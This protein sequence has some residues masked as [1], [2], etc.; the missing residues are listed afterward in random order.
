M[1]RLR[2][3]TPYY[4]WELNIQTLIFIEHWL[5]KAD[6]PRKFWG[7]RNRAY[8]SSLIGYNLIGGV[9]ISMLTSIVV[10]CGFDSRSCVKSRTIK[11]VYTASLE[12]MQHLEVRA[13]NQDN[14]FTR[15]LLFQWA[16][17]V[18]IQLTVLV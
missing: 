16:R 12:S 4:W 17:D 3:S 6:S 2:S 11:W 10:D 14:V 15:R 7:Y 5:Y 13:R 18:K 1:I 9:M 8:V